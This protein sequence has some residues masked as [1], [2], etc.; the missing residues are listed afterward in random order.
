MWA[1]CRELIYSSSFSLPEFRETL[2]KIHISS[3]LLF[4][5][6]FVSPAPT[7]SIINVPVQLW[8]WLYKLQSFK[9]KCCSLQLTLPFGSRGSSERQGSGRIL[10][11][12]ELYLLLNGQHGLPTAPRPA[13]PPQVFLVMP[14]ES[15][16]ICSLLGMQN[17]Y[18]LMCTWVLWYQWCVLLWSVNRVKTKEFVRFIPLFAWSRIGRQLNFPILNK[19]RVVVSALLQM[20]IKLHDVKWIKMI[21]SNNMTQLCIY[22]I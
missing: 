14:V 9:S 19:N 12:R 4:S 22:W 3:P 5:F 7:Y 6:H 21:H 17:C 15:P 18:N 8:L 20:D 10:A 11:C 2:V 16:K 13:P 1:I